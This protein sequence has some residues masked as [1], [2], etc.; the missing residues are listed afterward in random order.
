[1]A[2]QSCNKNIDSTSNDS[3]TT[4]LNVSFPVYGSSNKSCKTSDEIIQSIDNIISNAQTTLEAILDKK[5]FYAMKLCSINF[6][7]SE[8]YNSALIL[9]DQLKEY[10]D[11]L[12]KNVWI[13][14]SNSINRH[15]FER[16]TFI[17]DSNEP[18]LEEINNLVNQVLLSV[19]KLYKK[20]SGLQ[21]KNEDTKLLKYLIVQPLSAD[22][23]D[24][25][26]ISINK[27]LKNV[28]KLGVGDNVFRSC[29]PI[30]EQYALL[31]QYFITLQTTTYRVLSKMNYL[32][33]SLFTDLA[34]N[35]SNLY[36]CIKLI[37]KF[38]DL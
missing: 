10:I 5:T 18:P 6:I 8:K 11:L 22:L 14:Q 12:Y 24:C 21:T 23:K 36:Y 32:L 28:L 9:C 19:E 34:S 7:V 37:Q 38:Y 17:S 31:V 20:H 35:V 33:S 16:L 15:N 2:I 29:L 26:L 27:Q 30:F 13:S 25:D 4:L 1:M 3:V